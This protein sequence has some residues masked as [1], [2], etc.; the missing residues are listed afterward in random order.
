MRI[1]P[2]VPYEH[3]Y[4]RSVCMAVAGPWPTF[5]KS[6][7]VHIAACYDGAKSITRMV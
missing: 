5:K 7:V 1:V 6:P 3:G 4:R 2:M